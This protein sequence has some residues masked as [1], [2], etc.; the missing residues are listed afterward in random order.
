MISVENSKKG[1]PYCTCNDCGV[2]LFVRGKKGI[3]IF[4]SLLGDPQLR[5]E[6]K[7]LI[8]SVDY[9]NWLKEK[10]EEVQENQPIIGNDPDLELQEQ[11]IKKQLNRLRR[12]F[13]DELRSMK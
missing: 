9:Y 3:A 10:L 11:L 13:T 5:I 12:R 4:R 1:K 2:Q 7:D 6:S 8:N